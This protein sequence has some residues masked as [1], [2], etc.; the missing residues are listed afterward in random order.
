MGEVALLVDEKVYKN[1]FTIADSG[2]RRL[3]RC[4]RRA[5]RA[6]RKR[7]TRTDRA[8]LTL[9]RRRAR[10]AD[11]DGRITGADAVRFFQRSGL[12]RETLSR[13]RPAAARPQL[14]PPSLTRLFC[15]HQVWVIADN[16]RQ[17]FL[18]YAEFVKA[19]SAAPAAPAAGPSA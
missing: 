9:L 14:R 2:A 8:A 3:R 15:C 18:G 7:P 16:A 13:V 1:W 19:R 11:H 17:G 4:A 10:R 5:P 6:A 12:P